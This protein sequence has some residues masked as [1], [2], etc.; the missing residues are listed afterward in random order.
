MSEIQE[1]LMRLIAEA[2]VKRKGKNLADIEQ[3]VIG[4]REQIQKV[5]MQGLVEECQEAGEAT[6]SKKAVPDARRA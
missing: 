2:E 4:Y 3:L 1:R 5:L 6:G